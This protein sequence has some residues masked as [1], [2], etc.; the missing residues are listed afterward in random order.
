MDSY[1]EVDLGGGGDSII[2]RY[3]FVPISVILIFFSKTTPAVAW[4][5]RV[6]LAIVHSVSNF[7]RK[8]RIPKNKTKWIKLLGVYNQFRFQSPDRIVYE[9]AVKLIKSIAYLFALV[10]FAA[11]WYTFTLIIWGQ[12]N[13]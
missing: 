5:F 2:F 13:H 3:W 1:H 9:S 4:T 8:S 11:P 12:L 7:A 10:I 6:L